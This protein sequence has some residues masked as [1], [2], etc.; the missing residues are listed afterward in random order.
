MSDE[1]KIRKVDTLLI[2]YRFQRLDVLE[3]IR[4]HLQTSENCGFR[5]IKIA[6]NP[7]S[8][9]ERLQQRALPLQA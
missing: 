3:S 4:K 6:G 7:S 5:Y 9:L 2:V 1:E 8:E